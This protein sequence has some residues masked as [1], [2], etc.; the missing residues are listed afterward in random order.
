MPSSLI[1]S[2]V[3][4][5]RQPGQAVNP[6]NS[7]SIPLGGMLFQWSPLQSLHRRAGRF[8][9]R[10]ACCSLRCCCPQGCHRSR[11]SRF[12]VRAGGRVPVSASLGL[13]IRPLRVLP[14]ISADHRPLPR[15][16]SRVRSATS[17]RSFA[18][19]AISRYIRAMLSSSRPPPLGVPPAVLRFYT[20]R[21]PTFG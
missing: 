5:P 18:A 15:S 3:Q 6:E 12:L 2:G 4:N 10:R 17:A 11:S 21:T 20:V 8:A 19:S 7:V 13:G 16:L 9:G 14:L 1:Y